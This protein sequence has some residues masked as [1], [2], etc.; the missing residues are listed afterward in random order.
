MQPVGKKAESVEGA[1]NRLQKNLKCR[2]IFKIRRAVSVGQTDVSH[3]NQ[4]LFLSFV[5]KKHKPAQSFEKR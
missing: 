3:P 2:R 1:K 4:V 5:A